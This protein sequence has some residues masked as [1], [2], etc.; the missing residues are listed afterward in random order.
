MMRSLYA[1]VFALALASTQ[2]LSFNQ[3]FTVREQKSGP[4]H[5]TRELGGKN[6]VAPEEVT[7]EGIYT[8]SSAAAGPAMMNF[9]KPK[10]K[11]VI[12]DGYFIDTGKGFEMQLAEM[13]P[14]PGQQA[15]WASTP[16]Q[17]GAALGWA[18]KDI[19]GGKS[20]PVGY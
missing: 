2:A 20:N 4:S 14:Y 18:G 12:V 13:S 19:S 3:A 15:A 17:H 6:H 16:E 11:Q 8:Y 1:V 10:T 5:L 9:P 7:R